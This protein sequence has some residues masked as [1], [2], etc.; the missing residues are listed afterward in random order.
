MKTSS[1]NPFV[2]KASNILDNG[3]YVAE[4]YECPITTLRS[5]TKWRWAWKVSKGKQAGVE[6][7][8]LTERAIGEKTLPE[9][10]HH[11]AFRAKD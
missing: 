2:V 3:N 1:D 4:F 7:S 5:K 8:V 6:A 11:R 9:A 10:T